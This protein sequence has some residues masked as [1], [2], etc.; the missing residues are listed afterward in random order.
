MC[1]G[2]SL[3][4]LSCFQDV[5]WENKLL[6]EQLLFYRRMV[7]TCSDDKRDIQAM[8]LKRV[9]RRRAPAFLI[10][11]FKRF[12]R[13]TLSIG[14]AHSTFRYVQISDVFRPFLFGRQPFKAPKEGDNRDESK[15]MS[16][17]FTCKDMCIDSLGL[18][19]ESRVSF[20]LVV[21]CS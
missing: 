4:P 15:W 16:L 11:V 19:N 18:V 13:C 1:F 3:D 6:F 8:L 20:V 7:C 10:P 9:K 2:W 14:S 12:W 5:F 17:S 21:S